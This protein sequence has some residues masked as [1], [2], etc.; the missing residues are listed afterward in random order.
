[1]RQSQMVSH[2]DAIMMHLG[3]QI[4]SFCTIPILAYLAIIAFYKTETILLLSL[5]VVL[6]AS[7]HCP[8]LPH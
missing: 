2:P 7:Q 1:M 8:N 5:G 6:N 3:K 4:H